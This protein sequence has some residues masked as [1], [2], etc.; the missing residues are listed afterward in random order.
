MIKL[1]ITLI[2]VFAIIFLALN[3]LTNLS[4]Q[5]KLKVLYLFISITIIAGVYEFFQ[6]KSGDKNREVILKF[7]HGDTI[8]CKNVEVNNSNFNFVSGTLTFVGKKSDNKN[9]ILQV[10]ECK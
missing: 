9:L 10:E 4:K 3:L 7:M 8:V 1:I 6:D 5:D 2:G